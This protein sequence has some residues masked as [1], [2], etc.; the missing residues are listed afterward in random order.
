MKCRR[1]MNSESIAL[2]LNYSIK[3]YQ[4]YIKFVPILLFVII[5]IGVAVSK[6]ILD[7]KLIPITNQSSLPI[8]CK[9]TCDSLSVC[10]KSKLPKDYESY[11][12]ILLSSCY[13]KCPKYADK[14][15][16][17]QQNSCEEKFACMMQSLK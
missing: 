7:I 12:A 9:Q 17:C 3:K 15:S 13:V 10:I 2:K 11:H 6:R 4:I 16:K 14:V 8:F 1:S 5:V